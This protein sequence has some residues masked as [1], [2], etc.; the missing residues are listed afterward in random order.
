MLSVVY[1]ECRKQTQYA[2]CQ[3]AEFRYA[4]WDRTNTYY[5][6]IKLKI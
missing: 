6:G 3:Y 4:V 1:T 5:D 2:E